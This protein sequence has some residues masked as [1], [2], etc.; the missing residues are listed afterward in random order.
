M[1]CFI[2]SWLVVELFA[3][4]AL[5]STIDITNVTH[6]SLYNVRI[7][8]LPFTCNHSIPAA[9]QAIQQLPLGL[10]KSPHGGKLYG[11]IHTSERLDRSEKDPSKWS[12]CKRS[13]A[14]WHRSKRVWDR[15]KQAHVNTILKANLNWSDTDPCWMWLASINWLKKMFFCRW[16]ITFHFMNSFQ[17]HRP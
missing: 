12:E 13:N 2:T 6:Y 11:A 5:V 8:L 10:G 16:L 1:L 17:P 3:G 15:S 9:R 14:N 7:C 4:Y